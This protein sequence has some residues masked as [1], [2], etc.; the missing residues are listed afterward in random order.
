[1]SE[2]THAFHPEKSLEGDLNIALHL[3]K[4]PNHHKQK[5]AI[6]KLMHNI[7][8]VLQLQHEN[9]KK[10]FLN[11]HQTSDLI[12]KN[13]DSKDLSKTIKTKKIIKKILMPCIP[14]ALWNFSMHLYRK[15]RK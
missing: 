13:Q 4:D 7:T 9:Q 10:E 3:V 11:G 6:F 1:V 15:F 5:E 14:P 12:V 2:H 8:Y